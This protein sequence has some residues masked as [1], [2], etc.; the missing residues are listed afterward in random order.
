MYGDAMPTKIPA[1]VS[2][3]LA[4]DNAQDLDKIC[5]CFTQ[6]AQ[7]YDDS[8]QYQGRDAIRSWKRQS[9]AQVPCTVEP[10]EAAVTERHVKVRARLMG[11]F[12]G[13][14]ADRR[15]TFVLANGQIQ[16]LVIG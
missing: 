9:A 13:S 15:Y 7:V 2:A 11:N 4:A 5:Q 6:D 8:H 10:L 12:L 3:Y 16:S 1:V 14:P